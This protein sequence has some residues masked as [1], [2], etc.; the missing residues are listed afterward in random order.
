MRLFSP[1]LAPTFSRQAKEF[2]DADEIA[3]I[4]PTDELHH[5]LTSLS[6]PESKGAFSADGWWFGSLRAIRGILI[7][8][9]IWNTIS[10][11]A[12]LL[13][14]L[15]MQRL[16]SERGGWY[17]IIGL[18]AVIALCEI[19]KHII[20]YFDRL[21]NGNINRGVQAHLMGVLNRKLLAIDPESD[22]KFSRGNLKTLISSD[23][24]GV[25]DFISA[26]SHAWIPTFCM[27]VVLTPVVLSTMG[28]LGLAGILTALLQV[29][30]TLMF[31]T[32]IARMKASTQD[33]KDQVTTVM[34][35]WVRNIRLVRF[36]GL[37]D[38]FDRQINTIMNR[39]CV[40]AAR[41]HAIDCIMWGLSHNWWM[42]GLAS[43]LITGFVLN[44]PVEL[45]T[46]LPCC[47]ALLYMMS[48][49]NHIPYSISLYAQAAASAKRIRELLNCPELTRHLTVRPSPQSA[50][51][52]PVRLHLNQLVFKYGSGE[53]VI[54]GL[55]LSLDLHKRTAIIGA[56]GS[57][58]TTLLELLCGELHPSSGEIE[59]EFSS[60]VR[61]PL[62]SD[63]AYKL[64]R[65]RVAYSPQ[66]PYLSNA[67]LH[68]NITLSESPDDTQLK[69]AISRAQLE[70]DIEIL[71]HGVNEEVGETGINLSGGQ[72][73]RVS[74][75][76]A[77]YSSRP[78]FVLDD[79]L[80]AV[81]RQ[82]ELKLMQDIVRSAKGLVLVSHRLEE[83]HTCDRLL[84]LENGTV[85]EDGS[86]QAL[87]ADSSSKVNQYISAIASREQGGADEH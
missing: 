13:S 17:T 64:L 10:A 43:V 5:L 82:T 39:Y 76:R 70:P 49:F 21:R 63:E 1:S 45:S 26:A 44:I 25:E 8:R 73:Q 31:S 47:W 24:E 7:R 16:I 23:V 59:I 27:L 34:G 57:G 3:P 78:L 84:V 52:D 36:L 33:Q 83:L 40:T 15:S 62:W 6:A 65:S 20:G 32:V 53:P 29:P 2:F 66:A 11:C 71:R 61:A 46:F 68:Q 51:G 56:I 60:G 55:T 86:A 14:V 69:S 58:K 50:L 87:I 81:D 67:R 4:A 19:A 12:V 35:E 30:M 77:F 28:V 80:S 79:P 18:T 74:M 9:I 54:R 72:K 75:A 48:H 38:Y 41:M 22:Q 37:Q 42:F 85:V